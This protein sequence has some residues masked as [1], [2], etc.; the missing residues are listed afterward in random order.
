M[1]CEAEKSETNYAVYYLQLLEG[2]LEVTQGIVY[3]AGANQQEP[4]FMAYDLD[5][6]VSNDS[7][8]DADTAKAILEAGKNNYALQE[9]FPYS[10]YK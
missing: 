5:W 7:P 3:D 10:L 9:Y 1:A 4:W 6:D 8:V 2:K